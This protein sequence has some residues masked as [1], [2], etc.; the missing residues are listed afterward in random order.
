M[1]VGKPTLLVPHLTEDMKDRSLESLLPSVLAYYNRNFQR[2]FAAAKQGVSSSLTGYY[3]W[4]AAR[5]R[6]DEHMWAVDHVR[7]VFTTL[8]LPFQEEWSQM[9]L[10]RTAKKRLAA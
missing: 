9:A 1:P 6:S 5:S 2:H 4:R 10:L 3:D 7:R 8:G